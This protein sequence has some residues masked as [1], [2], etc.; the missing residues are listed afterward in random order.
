MIV[1]TEY[2]RFPKE[3]P[4]QTFKIIPRLIQIN[5]QSSLNAT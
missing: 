3:Y 2:K 1:P 4:V 5:L